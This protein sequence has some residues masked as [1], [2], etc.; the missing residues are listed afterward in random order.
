MPKH[1]TNRHFQ[2]ATGAIFVHRTTI[3]LMGLVAAWETASAGGTPLQISLIQAAIW[4]PMVLLVFP[5]SLWQTPDHEKGTVHISAIVCTLAG[6][7][8]AY[9]LL[10]PGLSPQLVIILVFLLN[11]GYAIGYGTSQGLTYNLREGRTEQHVARVNTISWNASRIIASILLAGTTAFG[12]PAIIGLAA[13]G[14]AS[15]L[16]LLI[17]L[18]QN[19]D[20]STPS[21]PRNASAASRVFRNFH[22]RVA[23]YSLLPLAIADSVA[24]SLA[25]A[26]AGSL[27]NL[28]TVTICY[29]V[30]AIFGAIYSR[31]SSP[32]TP[33]YRSLLAPVILSVGARLLIT[34]GSDPALYAGYFGIGA[35]WSMQSVTL[36]ALSRRSI[37]SALQA[38]AA[39]LYASLS[40]ASLTAGSLLWGMLA[41][42]TSPGAAII[43]S[44]GVLA[45]AIL[46]AITVPRSPRSTNPD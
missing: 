29:C 2:L 13:I 31:R 21:I 41:E 34:S 46:V 24:L 11:S 1:P 43:T 16:I 9:H 42:A 32:D 30:G 3:I 45:I 6:L 37:P 18:H 4:A 23:C 35:A 14:S 25:P 44:A 5:M 26:I 17:P 10:T 27:V 36:T 7:V 28:Q 38:N 15:L 22:F 12:S 8:L 20:L 33:M 19:T 40:F 39:G